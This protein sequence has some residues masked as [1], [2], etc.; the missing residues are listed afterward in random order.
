[1]KVDLS[2][3]YADTSRVGGWLILREIDHHRKIY[4]RIGVMKIEVRTAE[5]G[6][7]DGLYERSAKELGM[8]T[9]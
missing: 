5:T 8:T 7:M 9:V 1:M 2:Q 4:E 6:L 3:G